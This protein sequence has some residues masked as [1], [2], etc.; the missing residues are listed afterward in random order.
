MQVSTVNRA[1]CGAVVVWPVVIHLGQVEQRGG[2]G[3][4]CTHP[5]N[6]SRNSL[7]QSAGVCP[8]ASRASAAAVGQPAIPEGCR[9][10][11]CMTAA[12]CAA[13][14]VPI[15]PTP[16]P[17]SVMAIVSVILLS[18]T[19]AATSFGSG[20]AAAV[21]QVALRS[22]GTGAAGRIS[23]PTSSARKRRYHS[24]GTALKSSAMS[25]RTVCR[26]ALG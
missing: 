1:T 24:A 9:S 21:R 11:L 22:A 17:C 4:H 20:D 16:S 14:G 13:V 15:W 10:D 23:A 3:H 8:A 25:F 19:F 7:S 2:G 5:R 18:N 6:A 12:T 26:S